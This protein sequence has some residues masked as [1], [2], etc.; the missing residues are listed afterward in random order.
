MAIT[1]V[2]FALSG[3][4]DSTTLNITL[5]TVAAGD[6]LLLEYT[7]R[8]TGTGT[9]GGV[10]GSDW[11]N[12]ASDLYATSTFSHH[13]Y[14]KRCD[15]S[16]SGDAL[17]VTGLTNSCAGVVT[18][19]RG[20]KSV[21]DP[22]GAILHEANASANETM[23]QI[24]TTRNVAFVV[25]TVANSPDVAISAQTC[26]SPGALTERA[27]RL[28]T[29]GTDTSIAH[30]SA[31]K[32]TLGATG[33]LTWAQTNTAS[34][35]RAYELLPDIF[36]DR[37]QLI[38]NG[39]DSAQ[40]EG[41]GWD[42]VRSSIPVTAV[43]R[44]SNVVVTVTVPAL[45]TYDITADETITV[46]VPGAA[47]VGTAPI[48]AT[49]TIGVLA[50]T[51]IS[52][53]LT[54][55]LDALTLA[56]AGAVDVVG[57]LTV[58]L[59]T[60][61]LA[62]VGS[63]GAVP[64]SGVLTQTLDDLSVSASGGVEV[65][66]VSSVNLD[67]L[68]FDSMGV[69]EGAFDAVRRAILDG[70]DSDQ[71]EATGW[72]ALRS[73]IPVT[74]VVRTSATEVTITLPALPTYNLTVDETLTATVP[75]SALIGAAPLVATPTMAVMAHPG[76][77]GVLAQTLDV[78]QVSSAGTV[79]I[80]GALT[81]TLELLTTTATATVDVLGALT[82][83]LAAATLNSDG[84]VGSLPALGDLN[85]TLDPVALVADG[86]VSAGAADPFVETGWRQ[87]PQAVR[88][89][90]MPGQRQFVGFYALDDS[91]GLTGELTQTL[92]ALTTTATGTVDVIGVGAS[93]LDDL[94][95]LLFG[96]VESAGAV[97]VTLEPVTLGATATV[98]V[99]GVGTVTLSAVLLQ[100]DGVV[101]DAPNEGELT[102][103]LGT[104]TL[105]SAGGVE[106]LGAS[107]LVLAD[108]TL[109]GTGTGEIAGEGT[110]TLEALTLTATAT[111][112]V[113]GTLTVTLAALL[114]TSGGVI[115]LP[116]LILTVPA[117]MV[118]VP[119]DEVLV[120]VPAEEWLVAA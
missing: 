109:E 97:A 45:G 8:G 64:A 16:E 25:L 91:S 53:E 49:P 65:S 86:A 15:G 102:Q 57:V 69:V 43:V 118:V 34:S 35:S 11:T 59:E 58:T 71:A 116:A 36:D 68:T 46:T 119:L 21:G 52:G 84:V 51:P 83:T 29:T 30:A 62:A 28:N 60:I 87:P 98:D 117:Y 105:V 38:L 99:A 100:S 17:T 14:W 120:V 26:T 114:G 108:L 106:V 19:Y 95:V 10:G 23:A 113:D 110:P 82:S 6:V 18:L 7:H 48:V 54:Q 41:T 72:D 103:T 22:I 56:S 55:T 39:I 70:I 3:T 115:G 89:P 88:V 92:A 76:I 5:P 78:L 77:A 2:T 107:V 80:A 32:A 75:A 79:D 104:L 61:A 74:A 13:L 20:C 40:A 4:T 1:F 9:L 66:G 27:E 33:A 24:T 47:L 50:G 90:A 81:Q 37:R 112:A 93:T 44:S 94:G 85:Q 42:A 31:E 12:K 101:G 63:V 73:T 111:V 96:T 67:A